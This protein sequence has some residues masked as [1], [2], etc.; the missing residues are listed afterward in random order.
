MEG[1]KALGIL[2]GN[3]DE[4]IEANIGALF[5]PHGALFAGLDSQIEPHL[6]LICTSCP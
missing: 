5:M 2:K 4:M 6:R 3:I 1:L